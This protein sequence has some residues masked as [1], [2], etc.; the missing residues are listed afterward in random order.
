MAT[1]NFQQ[2][3]DGT[4][5]VTVND[6]FDKTYAT[7]ASVEYVNES[8]FDVIDASAVRTHYY[9]GNVFQINGVPIVGNG[10]TTIGSMQDIVN[11]LA[12]VFPNTNG[13]VSEDV[14]EPIDV[15]LGIGQSNFK[16]EGDSSL[17]PIPESGT[18]YQYYNGTV[19]EA[20]DPVGNAETGS[21]M[22]AF[23]IKWN[24]LSGRKIC[25]V[26]AAV[27]GTSQ[28]ASADVG[29][30]NWDTTGTLVGIAKGL[31]NDALTAL[32]A[33]GYAPIL[34]GILWCQGE[35]DAAAITAA[36]LTKA[37]YKSALT[38]MIDSFRTEFGSHL[39]FYIF[40]TGGAASAGS[41]D[42]RAAQEEVATADYYTDIIFRNAIDF[43]ARSLQNGAHYLQAGYNEMGEWGAVNAFNGA[44]ER[45]IVTQSDKVGIGTKLPTA[46]LHVVG[47][48]AFE[49]VATFSAASPVFAVDISA[50][51]NT[52]NIG[53]AGTPFNVAFIKTVNSGTNNDLVLRT[54]TVSRA[55]IFQ[56]STT[57]AA[58]FAATT[59]N[60]LLK[61]TTDV[62]SSL[63]TMN[64]TTQGF[65]PPRMTGAQ[66][67]AISSPAQGLI[68]FATATSGAITAVGF[69]G[70]NGSAWVQLG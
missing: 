11:E 25:F 15:F 64:S 4:V 28:V 67:L 30:G 14:P 17:S 2:K 18:V 70:Y 29:N 26:P 53:A 22:P 60:L 1:F 55:V 27:G 69:W 38:T 33:A 56:N 44:E 57:E 35:T 10:V 63:L 48:S 49:G 42:V 65:L 20:Q 8:Y 40:R 54:A 59:G 21:C 23:G 7:G 24:N 61:T 41:T 58:R 50:S 16:G 37:A 19:S 47:T 45:A 51:A 5:R 66:A 34:R 32:T 46:I 39:P 43:P 13:V 68:V 9:A 3:P 36:T 52:I 12:A 6:A 31:C 62:P